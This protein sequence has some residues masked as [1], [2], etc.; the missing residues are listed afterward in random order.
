MEQRVDAAQIH[1]SAE[2]TQVAH[3]AR[4]GHSR[5]ER[6]DA[7]AALLFLLF[8]EQHASIEDDV[9]VLDVELRDAATDFLA[10]QFLEIGG[11]AHAAA[12]RGQKRPHADIDRQAALDHLADRACDR[13]SGLE[14]RLEL[15]PILGPLRDNSG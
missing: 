4:D 11:L 9:F 2:I 1:E 7:L 5:L 14:R 15:R 3:R 8:L 10:H 6:S 12:G 13:R